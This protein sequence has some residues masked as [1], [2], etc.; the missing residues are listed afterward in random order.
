MIKTSLLSS[1]ASV[2][3]AAGT[4]LITATSVQAAGGYDIDCKLILC[5]AGGFPATCGDAFEHM[6]D[7][8]TSVPPKSPIGLCLLSDGTEY[9]GYDVDYS[10]ISPA[11]R[12]AF[13]CPE[14]KHLFHSV[15]ENDHGRKTVRAFCYKTA[16]QYG[17]GNDGER[18]TVYTGQSAPERF[19]FTANITVEPGTD[20]AYSPGWDKWLT[21]SHGWSNVSVTTH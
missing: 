16:T 11:D 8:I 14:G 4:S 6:I 17:W 9:K 13:S 7:R 21:S 18:T 19:N 10:W 20:A 2:V 12:A 1:V 15:S 3:I 5:L